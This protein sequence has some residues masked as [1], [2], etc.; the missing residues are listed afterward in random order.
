MCRTVW[1]TKLKGKILIYF[2]GRKTD[3]YFFFFLKTIITQRHLEHSMTSTENSL[4][5]LFIAVQFVVSE[6]RWWEHMNYLS[7]LIFNL[8]WPGEAG[9]QVIPK[10]QQELKLGWLGMA[11]IMITLLWCRKGECIALT[12]H[13]VKSY[14][15]HFMQNNSQFDTTLIT[16]TTC[17]TKQKCISC[18]TIHWSEE[19]D[20]ITLKCF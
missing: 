15:L 8:Y 17:A 7:V 10:L 13:Y 12:T 11:N 6:S 5:I 3:A 9:A 14:L 18:T 16:I 20:H 4:Y 1:G 2:T 19:S